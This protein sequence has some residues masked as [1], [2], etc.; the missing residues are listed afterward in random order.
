MKSRKTPEGLGEEE[1][2]QNWNPASMCKS[3]P[4]GINSTRRG[5]WELV[6]L[7]PLYDDGYKVSVNDQKEKSRAYRLHKSL[8]FRE[9]NCKKN[10]VEYCGSLVPYIHRNDAIVLWGSTRR[11]LGEG[12]QTPPVNPTLSTASGT[13]REW[14]MLK[15]LLCFCQGRCDSRSFR[16]P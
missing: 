15:Y 12:A 4:D 16:K 13:G 9:S 8:T 3:R 2:L 1:K 11:D 5:R 6:L 10:L 14:N 7:N